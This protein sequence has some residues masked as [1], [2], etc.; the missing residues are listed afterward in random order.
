MSPL[1]HMPFVLTF[2]GSAAHK[3]P[4]QKKW[5][6]FLYKIPFSETKKWNNFANNK[7]ISFN[8][9]IIALGL[10]FC[11]PFTTSMSHCF[12]KKFKKYYLIIF[13]W[14][15]MAILHTGIQHFD[16]NFF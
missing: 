13:S 2:S 4:D 8:I 14:K 3:H 15:I 11:D 16:V 9:P 5:T 1:V 6:L 7:I 10:P 12:K